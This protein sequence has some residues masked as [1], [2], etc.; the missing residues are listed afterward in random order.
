MNDRIPALLI[1]DLPFHIGP[2]ETPSNPQ[3]VPD[4][5]PFELDF[6]PGRAMLVQRNRPELQELLDRAYRLGME[7]GT[8]LADDPY[9]TPYAEDFLAFVRARAVPPGRVLEIGAGVGYLSKRLQDAGW[10]VDSLE[11][12]TGYEDHWR[13]FGLDVINDYFPSTRAQGPYDLI[14]CYAV[15]EHIPD[16][17]AFLAA[18]R[19]HLGLGGTFV[20]SVPDCAVEIAIGD[21]AMLLHEHYNYFDDRALRVLLERS[22]FAAEM[23]P[24]GFGRAIYAA[25]RAAAGGTQETAA[26]NAAR[27]AE[28][29]PARCNAFIQRARSRLADLARRGT[30]GIYCPTRALATLAKDIDCRFFDDSPALQGRFVPPFSAPIE[31]RSALLERPVDVLVIMSHTFAEKLGAELQRQLPGTRI[32][33]IAD[34]VRDPTGKGDL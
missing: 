27:A 11:P 2:T 30:L 5:F 9:G 7:I 13:R 10:T 31:P 6:D 24:S 25:A 21:P 26:D 4:T 22:G 28:T 34:L 20:V 18:V 14:C 23:R 8:P 1:P 15:L 33:A 12:G 3:G 16:P 29:F 32:L 17:G 19:A